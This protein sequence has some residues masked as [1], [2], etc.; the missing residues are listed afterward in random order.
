MIETRWWKA[1]GRLIV[2]CQASEGDALHG[3][4]MMARFARAA[5]DGGAGAIRAHGAA[6]IA[7]IRAAVDVP[8]LGIHKERV[9]DGAILITPAFDRAKSLAAAG[10]DA[11][12]LDCTARGVRHGALE[13]LRRI[14]RE[15]GLPVM[16]DIATLEEAEAAEAA[17]ADFVLS[18]M[19]GFTEDTREL[20]RSFE[21][22]FIAELVRRLQVPVIAEGRIACPREAREAV[23]AGA[24]AVVVGTAITRPHELAR[25]YAR[26]V[27]AAGKPAWTAA[28]DLGAT[29]IKSGVAGWDGAVEGPGSVATSHEGPR[30]LLEQLQGILRGMIAG[31]GRTLEAVGVATAG[32][33]DAGS[34]SI[35]HATGNLENWTGARIGDALSAVTDLPVYVENDAICAAA[36]EWRYGAARGA[37]NAL[38]VTLGTGIGAGAV[39][40]G[41]LLRGAH[42]LANM[43]GHTPLPGSERP[44]N[45]GLRGCVEAETSAL[46]AR[47]GS[48]PGAV[49]EYARALAAGLIPAIHVLDPEVLVM[50]GGIAAGH[51]ELAEM[52]ERELS[53]GTLAWGRRRLA[54]RIPA[55]SEMAGVRGAAA[56]AAM[57]MRQES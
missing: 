22:G 31:A 12:A 38:C 18:T 11:I 36:G 8:V 28:I 14:K 4:G 23:E 13:R 29:N 44:C 24:W 55:R 30:A 32:W 46:S 26:A 7:E 20:A 21:P 25:G 3:A 40:E 27:E 39:V 19:R 17:G 42:G 49:I 33:V 52:V 41:R 57:R 43:V 56:M 54:V 9:D 37:R 6:D 2:S 35:L 45:C 53:Q 48:E 47:L 15:L 5:V 10:A 34:G 50:T 16:A 1:K 51:P